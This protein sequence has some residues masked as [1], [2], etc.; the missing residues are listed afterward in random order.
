MSRLL[1]NLIVIAGA[2]LIKGGTLSVRLERSDAGD[3]ILHLTAVGEVIKV[4][5][6]HEHSGGSDEVP[7]A[8]NRPNLP[9][10]QAGRGTG[11]NGFGREFRWRNDYCGFAAS[12]AH[13]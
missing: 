1:L 3:K 4:T 5:P 13:A 11:G 6:H 8:R 9:H 10:R 12:I 2:S 7:S